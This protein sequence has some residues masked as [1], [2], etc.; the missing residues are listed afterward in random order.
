[1]TTKRRIEAL[2]DKIAPNDE[3]CTMVDW[4]NGKPTLCSKGGDCTNCLVLEKNRD[5]LH[6]KWV[7]AH[8]KGIAVNGRTLTKDSIP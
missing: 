2:E 1:M 7:G 4:G 3:R 6:I 8:N 5:V